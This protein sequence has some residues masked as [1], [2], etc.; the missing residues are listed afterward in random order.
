LPWLFRIHAWGPAIGPELRHAYPEAG[1]EGRL[2]PT[3][4]PP[5]PFFWQ[6]AF[7]QIGHVLLGQGAPLSS[8]LNLR[9][10]AVWLVPLITA[11]TAVGWVFLVRR[12][13]EARRLL[14]LLLAVVTCHTLAIWLEPRLFTPQRHVAYGLPL[15][16]LIAIPSSLGFLLEATQRW[17]RALPLLQNVLL[18][19]IVGGHGAK[20]AGY[21]VVIPEVD[22]PLFAAIAALPRECV[23]G[24]FPTETSDSIPYLARRSVYLS[25]EFHQ[26]FHVRFTDL[27]R[28][29]ARKLFAAYFASSPRA[30]VRFRDE[31]HVTHLLINAH[32][33]RS[34]PS[35]FAPFDH[36][37]AAA[38][39]EGQ[40]HG[41]AA[42]GLTGQLS[43]L[44]AGDY[45]LLDLRR[46]AT[47][48]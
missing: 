11:L 26:P 25:R 42:L 43:V 38:F 36:D 39:A 41:F 46:L 15:F 18:L 16:A 44:R 3:N 21:S 17:R 30:L 40:R 27:M 31:E 22:R 37:I 47:G 32:H 20:N 5:F 9:G 19:A 10:S 24:A 33:F 4:R 12:R 45:T 35:Y 8:A 1:P 2:D 23:V 48:G 29:R 7:E 34:R 28:A 13:L 14:L 6:V